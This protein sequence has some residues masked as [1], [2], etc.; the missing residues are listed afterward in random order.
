MTEQVSDADGEDQVGS[1]IGRL[2]KLDTGGKARLRRNAGRSLAESRGV[3]GLFYRLLPADVPAYDHERYFLIA[4]LFPLAAN[5]NPRDLGA[6]LRRARTPTNRR[7]LDRRVEILL[8]ADEEQLRFR[9]RQAVRFARSNR[10][11]VNWTALLRDVL[12][13]ERP[14][15]YVQRQ[16]AQSYFGAPQPRNAPSS[17]TGAAAGKTS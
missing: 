6:T 14:G 17:G 3:L 7:G 13:W 4:T 16:W 8:D 2:E 15:R 9:L 1:F 10:V 11:A 5:G 12:R